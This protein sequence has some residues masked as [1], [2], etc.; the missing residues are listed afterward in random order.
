M[1]PM[2]DPSTSEELKDAPILLRLHGRAQQPPVNSSDEEFHAALMA[3]IAQVP[4]RSRTIPTFR[5]P[6]LLV[7]LA[8]AAMLG[9]ILFLMLDP[10]PIGNVPTPEALA[11]IDERELE[12]LIGTEDLYALRIDGYDLHP[13][14]DDLSG[15]ALIDHLANNHLPLDLI[16]EEL[17][18]Q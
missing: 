11:T 10:E 14:P 7:P 17:P 6:H 18:L 9:G 12:W 15:E 13:L 1:E 3:R 16:L 5:V 8:A 4:S 2:N